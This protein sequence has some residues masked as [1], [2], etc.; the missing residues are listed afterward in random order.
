MTIGRN[1]THSR[2][3]FCKW[4]EKL[5]PQSM[6]LPIPTVGGTVEER[7]GEQGKNLEKKEEDS[8]PLHL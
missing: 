4:V 2:E 6:M 1:L 5:P 3:L 8:G 7:E